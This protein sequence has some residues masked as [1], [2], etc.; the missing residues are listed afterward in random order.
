MGRPRD[1]VAGRMRIEYVKGRGVLRLTADGGEGRAV[2]VPLGSL[3]EQLQIDRRHLAPQPRVL[4]FAGRHDRPRRGAG[5]LVG[6]F[7]SEA[8][9]RAAFQEVRGTTSDEEGW[10]ELVALDGGGRRTVL[11]WFGPRHV[12]AVADRGHH[13][14]GRRSRGHLRLLAR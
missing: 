5:E 7:E 10:A 8:D 12:P 3:V 9:G 4:L 13:P 6:W 1:I 14:A 11:A 2:E